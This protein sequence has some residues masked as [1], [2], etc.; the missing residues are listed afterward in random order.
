MLGAVVFGH[1]Q[2]QA[3]INV[4]NE[5]ADE[6]G[7][8]AWDW[9]PPAKDQAL[10]ERMAQM[11]ES[12]LRQAYEIRGK[13]ER[14]HRL[15]E[16][17]GRVMLELASEAPTPE[18]LIDARRRIQQPGS[19]DRPQPDPRRRAAHRRPRHAHRAADHHPHRRA[20]RA[21]TARALHPRRDAG[22]RHRDARHL[23]RRAD[24][25]RAAGRVSRALHDALQLPAV[26]DRRDRPRG[27][28]QAPRD[29]PR[30]ARQARAAGRAADGRRVRLFAARRLRD[31]RIERLEL[32]G[33]G[34]R[35]LPRADGR[36]RAAESARRG[37]RDGPH[38]G[39]QPLRRADRHPRRRGPSRRHGL[40]G[41]RHRERRHR[42]ADGHQDPGHHRRRSCTPRSSRR[43]KA[44]C[45]S[46]RK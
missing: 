3:V 18:Q 30:P 33:F 22:D 15:D 41:G 9:T 44:A 38:Q 27:L 5:L 31:H 14:T 13:Q 37:H 46:W 40:Q 25:R 43:A 16:I 23:A 2:M 42:A 26:F 32:D 8:P 36:R 29:R 10:I 11:A 6:A 7:K 1:E 4:I 12:D 28:A 24:H 45:T 39:R 34:V 21:P 17:R 35:R 19:E 20:C